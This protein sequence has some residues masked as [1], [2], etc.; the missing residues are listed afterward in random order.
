[1]EERLLDLEIKLAFRDKLVADLDALV[2][3][4]GDRVDA[5]QRE[6]EQ[7][8]KALVSPELPVGPSNDRPPHY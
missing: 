1:M 4:L 2:R 7:L 6:L 8:K 5:M 3:T